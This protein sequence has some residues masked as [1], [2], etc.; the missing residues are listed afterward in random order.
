M[1]KINKEITY[2][3]LKSPTNNFKIGDK[4]TINIK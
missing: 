1:K 4:L 2:Q 3:E